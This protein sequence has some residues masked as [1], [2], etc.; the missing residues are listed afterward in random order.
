MLPVL[1]KAIHQAGDFAIEDPSL[2]ADTD[3][4]DTTIIAALRFESH[5]KDDELAKD[6]ATLAR[7]EQLLGL[8]DSAL[9]KTSSRCTCSPSSPCATTM[10]RSSSRC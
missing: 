5:G 2:A 7:E 9:R 4:G 10:H 3:T 8:I 1:A 6:L